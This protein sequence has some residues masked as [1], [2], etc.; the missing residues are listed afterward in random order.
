[1]DPNVLD[2]EPHLALFVPDSDPL[3][4]YRK[5]ADIAIKLLIPGGELFSK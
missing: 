3:L 4:F 5:I 2:F 1:M